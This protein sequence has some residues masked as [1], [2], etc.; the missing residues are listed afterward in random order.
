MFVSSSSVVGGMQVRAVPA[1]RR[2]QI[3]KA[4]VLQIIQ[5]A[6]GREEEKLTLRTMQMTWE[7]NIAG[8]GACINGALEW[9][10]QRLLP[11]EV[12]TYRPP[13]QLVPASSSPDYAGPTHLAAAAGAAADVEGTGADDERDDSADELAVGAPQWSGA[14]PLGGGGAS[15]DSLTFGELDG[16]RVRGPSL[17]VGRS[18]GSLADDNSPTASP[19]THRRGASALGGS[20]SRLAR[21]P[22]FM[23][24]SSDNTGLDY[25]SEDGSLG[26]LQR[27][28]SNAVS[29]SSLSNI[30][31]SSRSSRRRSS[32]EADELLA[33]SAEGLARSGSQKDVSG[34]GGGGSAA[35]GGAEKNRFK[36]VAR[37][38]MRTKSGKVR[39]CSRNSGFF[40]EGGC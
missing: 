34:V 9:N 25:L 21:R 26:D 36:A 28:S 32:L 15:Q 18:L 27:G 38:I 35:T 22:G 39:S 40:G 11:H 31:S 19:R 30:F 8:W 12:P 4:L 13:G 23:R 24:S 1:P 14:V 10:G 33:A 5:P 3:R 7:G 37:S 20:M 16:S 17:G 2:S 29:T 6:V